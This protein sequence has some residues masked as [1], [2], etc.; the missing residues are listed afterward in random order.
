MHASFVYTYCILTLAVFFSCW[1]LQ[2]QTGWLMVSVLRAGVD[3]GGLMDIVYRDV[4]TYEGMCTVMHTMLYYHYRI[5]CRKS[6]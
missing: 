6:N 3:Y 2:L 1:L 4:V 5:I